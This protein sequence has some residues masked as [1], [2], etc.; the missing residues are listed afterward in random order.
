[1][2]DAAWKQRERKLAAFFG[3]LRTVGS[4]SSY[5]TGKLPGSSETLR[6]RADIEHP[7]LFA[8]CKLRKKHSTWTL[9]RKT[10]G[11]ANTEGKIPVVALAEKG[12]PGLLLVIHTDDFD[13]VMIERLRVLKGD[14]WLSRLDLEP[15]PRNTGV[16]SR[17]DSGALPRPAR[18][19]RNASGTI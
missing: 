5:R 2:P 6:T 1:M 3:V 19:H 4:G 11:H 18:E 13:A 16:D 17:E 8:E 14:R 12:K 15:R 9:F 10:R 7:V